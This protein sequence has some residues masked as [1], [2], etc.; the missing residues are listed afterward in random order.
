MTGPLVAIKPRNTGLRVFAGAM[1]AVCPSYLTII[2]ALAEIQ[3]NQFAV[4]ARIGTGMA[5]K[6][7]MHRCWIPACAGMTVRGDGA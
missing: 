4:V 3:R 2:L 7:V 6:I 1:A 5:A